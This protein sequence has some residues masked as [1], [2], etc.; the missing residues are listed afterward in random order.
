MA[1]FSFGAG[2][3]G[4]L[5]RIPLYVAGR[6]AT[7][8]VPR[9]DRWVFGCGA[10][11]G[12]GAL[13]LWEVVRAHGHDALWLTGSAREAADA[14]AR[15]IR[16][17]PKHGLRGWWATARAGV[18]VVTH[19]FGDVNRYATGGALAVQLW[20]GIPLKRIGLDSAET[21]RLPA[22][23]G[24]AWAQRLLRLLYR[25]TA[26]RIGVLPAASERARGRLE[27]AFG[28][29]SGRVLV[30]G[31]PRVD[32]LSVG[33]PATRRRAASALLHQTLPGLPVESRLILY[34]PTWR[35]GAADPAVPTPQ[36]WNE[37]TAMLQRQNAVLLVRSHPLGAGVY[38]PPISSERVREIGSDAASD[39]TP[40]LPAIDVLVTDYSSL[41]YDV[42]LLDMPVVFLA[43]DAQQYALTRG[44]YG[45][46]VDVAGA[47]AATDWAAAVAQVERILADAAEFAQ[48]SERSRTLSAQM[49]AH[50]DGRNAQ[51]VYVATV[52]RYRARTRWASEGER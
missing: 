7:L 42:G 18:V 30:T 52:R 43:P 51:R 45:S 12:D 10:G 1:S 33:Q 21:T 47:D 34:A 37:I 5:A 22:F 31:E 20:H 27:S 16:T 36:E 39:I 24:S 40:Y 2:N 32:V 28:L 17:A 11:I 23:P 14:A 50:R 9:A 41:A 48:R 26:R 4:K 19:G 6:A 3:L 15:G 8:V 44:F 35:D 49:H 46:F 25:R 29:P 38:A 13:A